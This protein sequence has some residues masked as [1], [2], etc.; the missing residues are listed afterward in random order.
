MKELIAQINEQIAI[1]Q[2]GSQKQLEK[3]NSSAGKRAR[4]A[5]NEL[6]K[7]LKEFRKQSIQF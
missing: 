7:L 4:S 5:S 2:E 3:G 1:F 6:T